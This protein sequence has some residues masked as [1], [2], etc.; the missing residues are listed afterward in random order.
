[1]TASK[2]AASKNSSSNS[3]ETTSVSERLQDGIDSLKDAAP[4][5]DEAKAYVKDNTPDIGRLGDTTRDF[6]RRNPA[7]SVAAAAG[8]GVVL[9]LLISKRQ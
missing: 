2:A 9:G 7:M 5:V 4:S 8:V 1:M 6:V 3:A